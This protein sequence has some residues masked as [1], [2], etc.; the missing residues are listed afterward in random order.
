MSRGSKLHYRQ[1]P[2]ESMPVLSVPEMSSL[3]HEAGGSSGRE[4]AGSK[5]RGRRTPEQ[6]GSGTNV[7][8]ISIHT[9]IRLFKNETSSDFWST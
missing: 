4:A 6:F 2:T 5:R 8:S 1:T 7:G 3:R 9:A